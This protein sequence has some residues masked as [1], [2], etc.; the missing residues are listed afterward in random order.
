MNTPIT[1]QARLDWLSQAEKGD[2]AV[3]ITDMAKLEL[4][5]AAL[6]EETDETICGLT[7]ER[8]QLRARVA[9]LLEYAIELAGE[10]SWKRN[11]TEANNREMAQ[12]DAA[13]DAARKESKP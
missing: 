6:R 2:G 11:S 3:F 13:I 12:L 7:A 10:W 9:D 8:D 1:D 4:E 5:L